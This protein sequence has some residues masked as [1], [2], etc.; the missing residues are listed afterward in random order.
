MT[1]NDCGYYKAKCSS[2]EDGYLKLQRENYKLKKRL[3][4][5]AYYFRDGVTRN[6]LDDKDFEDLKR[7]SKI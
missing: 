5:I 2:L 4:A 1:D 3:D 6:D 7:L